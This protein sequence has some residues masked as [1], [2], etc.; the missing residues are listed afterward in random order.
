MKVWAKAY[1]NF[2]FWKANIDEKHLNADIDP[3]DKS[4]KLFN[5]NNNQALVP[6]L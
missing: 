2:W 1:K 5:N 6:N 3:Q 4:V